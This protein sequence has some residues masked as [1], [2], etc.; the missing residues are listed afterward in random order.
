MAFTAKQ[1]AQAHYNA[2]TRILLNL[3]PSSSSKK[4]HIRA[5]NHLQKAVELDPNSAYS[6]HNLGHAWYKL[7]EHK[8]FVASAHQQFKN[9]QEFEN[10][11]RDTL[12]NGLNDMVE[13]I[14][15]QYVKEHAGDGLIT[16]YFVFALQAVDRALEIQYDFPQAHN[17]RAMILAKLFRLDEAMQATEVALSQAPDYKNASENREKIKELIRE[18]ATIPDYKE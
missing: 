10:A 13:K 9:M 15:E 3:N 8:Y 1:K 17:T 5:V 4:D 12:N 2:G 11:I 6:Y 14:R 16:G 7:A 18:R